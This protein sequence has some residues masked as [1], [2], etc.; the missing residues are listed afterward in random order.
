MQTKT[1]AIYV[2]ANLQTKKNESA[3]C[4]V[5]KGK[6]MK[7]CKQSPKYPNVAKAIKEARVKRG[8]SQ[9][10][11]SSQLDYT[12]GQF[13]SNIERGLCALPDDKIKALCEVLELDPLVIVEATVQ[14]YRERMTAKIQ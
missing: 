13:I 7:K 11:L 8:M 1:D 3:Q 2:D 10:F 4:A 9:E 6:F 14:D 12:K 5:L